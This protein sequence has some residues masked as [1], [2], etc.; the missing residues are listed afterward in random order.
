[1]LALSVSVPA[2]L[3]VTTAQSEHMPFYLQVFFRVLSSWVHG[4]KSKR[5]C[6]PS[7]I[8]PPLRQFCPDASLVE[9]VLGAPTRRPG[10]DSNPPSPGDRGPRLSTPHR[11]G[12]ERDHSPPSSPAA[13]TKISSQ[14]PNSARA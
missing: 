7:P 6:G 4:E 13:V 1:V 2:K 11:R 3:R 12:W 14:R 8:S 9:I 10:S 5:M